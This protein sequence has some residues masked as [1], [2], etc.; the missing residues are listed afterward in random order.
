MIVRANCTLVPG[1]KGLSENIRVRSI[2]GRFLEHS[3]LYCFEADEAKSYY[4]GQR[5]PDAAQPRPPD[6]G[7]RAGRGHPRPQRAR[8]DLQGAARRQHACVGA[9]SRTGLGARHRRRRASASVGPGD[10]HAPARARPPTRRVRIKRRHVGPSPWG[11]A[12]GG[13]RRRVEH[14]APRRR[15]AAGSRSARSARCCASAPTSRA[16]GPIP[17][18]KLALTA[19]RRRAASP[20][21]ARAE[22]VERLEVLITS[23]GRQAANGDDLAATLGRPPGCPVRILSAAEE[24]R[25]AFVG[26]VGVASP[27]P[28]RVGRR[29]RRRRR[30]RADRDRQPPRPGRAVTQSIDLGSQRLTSRLLADDP[31]GARGR[32]SARAP[33][34]RGTST[35]RACRAVATAYA[36]GGSARALK[37]I[38]GPQLGAVRARRRRSIC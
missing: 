9:A 28:R 24:G 19:E 29:R 23:P 35:A 14:R 13:R 37:R 17:P 2:L 16:H 20:T 30:L 22:R 32:P 6:R 25:L 3:R 18:D 5:R 26:A 1:V 12:G 33:R 38:V 34:W 4:L 27:P 10:V 36:V 11:H 31:P 21:L 7:R 8:I 15:R